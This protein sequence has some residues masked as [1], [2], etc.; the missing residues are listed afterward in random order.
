VNDQITTCEAVVSD[1]AELSAVGQASFRAA[2]ENWSTPSD[3]E[4]HLDEYFSEDAVLEA[5]QVPG[6]HF[7]LA[8]DDGAIA[9]FVKI[10]DSE[11]PDRVPVANAL[12]LHQVYVHP[13]QQRFGV[14]ERLLQAA[15]AHAVAHAADGVW[16]TVW[17]DAPWAV[18]FYLKHGFEQVGT[19][20]FM[21]GESTFNDLL[22]WRPVKG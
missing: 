19:I 10:R 14:G 5:M 8:R 20:D 15:F 17:E 3:L 12:E 18:N 11:K 22:M 6:C 9:G 16:L 1:A 21:L 2:Y 4:A 13:D 7:L